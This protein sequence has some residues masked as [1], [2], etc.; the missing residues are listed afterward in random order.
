[1]PDT[2]AEVEG[3]VRWRADPAHMDVQ[4]PDLT[5]DE[6]LGSAEARSGGLGHAQARG[7]VEEV[8]MPDLSR[9]RVTGGYD[10][11]AHRGAPPESG[12]LRKS[13]ESL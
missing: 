12:V 7:L 2:V 11:G 10:G 6:R 3:R 1:M 8:R 4:W 5:A 9:S 13:W